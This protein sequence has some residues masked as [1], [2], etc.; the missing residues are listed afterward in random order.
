MSRAERRCTTQTWRVKYRWKFQNSLLTTCTAKIAYLPNF[1]VKRLFMYSIVNNLIVEAFFFK[2]I[3]STITESKLTST[4]S[5]SRPFFHHQPNMKPPNS[6]FTISAMKLPT[7]RP[8]RGQVLEA[9][10]ARK[11]G[12]KGEGCVEGRIEEVTTEKRMKRG[13]R[14]WTQGCRGEGGWMCWGFRVVR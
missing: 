12:H 8:S 4:W 9:G 13:E 2:V 1:S 7:W 14:A 10:R 6:P 11:Q 3:K 5:V